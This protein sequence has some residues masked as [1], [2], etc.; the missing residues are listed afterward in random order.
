MLMWKVKELGTCLQIFRFSTKLALF[1]RE[2]IHLVTESARTDQVGGVS[3]RDF[4]TL[5]QLAF[6]DQSVQILVEVVRPL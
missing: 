1:D 4:T 6:R 2:Y 5:D 3:R